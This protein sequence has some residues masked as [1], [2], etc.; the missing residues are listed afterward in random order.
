MTYPYNSTREASASSSREATI[1][2]AMGTETTAS[3]M[4]SH[5]KFSASCSMYVVVFFYVK[6]L[7]IPPPLPRPLGHQRWPHDKRQ[8]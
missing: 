7:T 2:L 3:A 6:S 5:P 8:L 1:G 4:P